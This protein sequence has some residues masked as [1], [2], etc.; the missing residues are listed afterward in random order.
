MV[1]SMIYFRL[2]KPAAEEECFAIGLI[3]ENLPIEF[4]NFI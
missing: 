1:I 2:Y 4:K 3:K